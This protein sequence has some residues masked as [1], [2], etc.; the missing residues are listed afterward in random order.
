MNPAPPPPLPAAS[1]YPNPAPPPP[2][3]PPPSVTT[4]LSDLKSLLH[5]SATALRSLPTPIH[6]ETST[7]AAATFVPCPFNPNHRLPPSILFSHYLNCPSPLS[8]PHTFHYPLTRSSS[9][10]TTAAPPTL[11]ADSSELTVSLDNYIAYNAPANSFFYQN[12]PGPVTP[13]APPPSSFNLPR[14]L[15]TECADFNEEPRPEAAALDFIR[16]LPSEI[17]AIRGEIESWG[18]GFPAAYSSRILRAILRLRDCKLLHL[19]DWII[20]N[21]PR[22]GVIID[23]AMRDHVVLLVKLSLKVIV[24]EALELAG[25]TY[26]DG[27]TKEMKKALWGLGNQSFECPVLVRVVVWLAL[28][29]NVLYGEVNGMYFAVALLKECVLNSASRAS[30][31]SLEGEE[32]G[33]SEAGSNGEQVQSVVSIDKLLDERESIECETVGNTR[34][35]ISEVAA[36]VAA[37]HE[38]AFIE[39]KI[40]ALR[41][42]RPTSTYQRNMEHAHVSKIADEE[43]KKRPDYRPI[44][45]YDGFLRHRSSNQDANKV[46]TKEELLAEERDYKRRRMSYRGKKLKR[47]TVEVM[48]G[49]IDEYMEELRQAEGIDGT[50]KALEENE[51]LA[52][53]NMDSHASADDDFGSRRNS[54]VPE[55]NFGRSVGH[56]KDIHSRHYAGDFEDDNQQRRQ[57]SSWDDWHQYPNR[58]NEG[59]RYDRDGTSATRDGRRSNSRARVPMHGREKSDFVEAFAEDDSR[60]SHQRRSESQDRK[61]HKSTRDEYEHKTHKRRRDEHDRSNRKRERGEDYWEHEDRERSKRDRDSGERDEDKRGHVDRRKSKT[62]RSSSSRRELHEFND[63]YDP[64]VSHDLY[65]DDY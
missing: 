12:C 3:P 29:L 10:S 43:R 35:F 27:E 28:Q 44:I 41:N 46:K 65:Q 24:G 63:R 8:L 50:S 26:S 62:T 30:L 57:D 25:F 64:L 14:V 53:K 38:R 4:A 31:F 58:S 45:E 54:E 55:D 49:I 17:F 42:A 56:R 11:P 48:R 32:D 33:L 19:Y 52:S 40:K 59:I 20:A 36:A 60:R 34:I 16:F 23:C 6:A 15:Y 2:P 1:Y 61:Y 39:D 37:L 47:N 9:S 18:G 22:Y 7:A 51:T 13:S 5:L 21:S